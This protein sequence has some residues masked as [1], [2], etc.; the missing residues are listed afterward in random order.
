MDGYAVRVGTRFSAG[1]FIVRGEAFPSTQARAPRLD[2]GEAI[3]ITTGAFLPPGANAVARVE[4]ARREGDLLYLA[5]PVA[6]GHDVMPSGEALAR[7]E[8]LLHRGE[9]VG[10]AHVGALLSQGLARLRVTALRVTVL[11][12][13]DELVAAGESTGRGRWDFMGPTIASS[14]PFAKVTVAR[15][16][17]DD[18]AAVGRAL[19]NAARMSDLLL[20]IGGSSVGRRDVTKASIREMGELWFEGVRANVLKRGAAGRVGHVPVVV[21][22]GQLVSA[23]TVYHEHGLHLISR[24][25][26]RELRRFEPAILGTDLLVNHRLDSTYLL[27]VTGGIA[28]PLPWG[29][30][31]I[32]ALLSADAFTVLHRGRRYRKGDPITIQRLWTVR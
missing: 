28:T 1:P 26:G 14:L 15:P 12:V 31:R 6:R 5:S 27:A 20:T 23:V 32:S 16:L 22:P 17:P 21:L 25:V 29:V 19:K 10:P 18:R 7:G 2:S 11:P 4:V 30:A 13:G 24:L 8:V 9:S 3:Y